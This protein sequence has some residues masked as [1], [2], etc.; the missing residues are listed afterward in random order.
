MSGWSGAEAYFPL[1]DPLETTPYEK[2]QDKIHVDGIPGADHVLFCIISNVRADIQAAQDH[3]D[4]FVMV[5]SRLF[6]L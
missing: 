1:I 3:G 5:A 6:H 2:I 4:G